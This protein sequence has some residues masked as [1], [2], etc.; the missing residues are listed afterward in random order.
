MLD[1]FA[2]VGPYD[3]V[4]AMA[5]ERYEGLVEEVCFTLL[6]PALDTGEDGRL[7]GRLL[8]DLKG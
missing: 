7:L 2:V 3:E 4:G 8:A 6:R 5:R 1:A